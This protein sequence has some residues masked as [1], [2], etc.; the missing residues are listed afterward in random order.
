MYRYVCLWAVEC[1]D[2]HIEH[3]DNYL[4]DEGPCLVSLL[5]VL[6][7]RPS[8]GEF[9]FFL[10]GGFPFLVLVVHGTAFSDRGMSLGMLRVGQR[11]PGW[12][13]PLHI[14]QP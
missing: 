1:G 7:V 11:P 12:S 8:A 9:H 4:D 6:G 10:K 2:L 3:Y 14:P 5:G 13:I